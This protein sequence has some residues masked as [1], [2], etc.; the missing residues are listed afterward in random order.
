MDDKY[1]LKVR[2]QPDGLFSIYRHAGGEVAD[3]LKGS[4]TSEVAAKVAIAVYTSE[5]DERVK[6]QTPKVRKKPVAKSR[7]E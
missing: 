5:K 3:S 2:K 7:S 4:F 6:A 1:T